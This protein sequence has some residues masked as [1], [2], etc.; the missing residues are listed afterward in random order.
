MT[1]FFGVAMG[2][3]PLWSLAVE[4]HFYILWPTVIHKLKSGSLILLLIA[5]CVLVPVARAIAFRYDH[6]VGIDWYTWFVA[7]GLAIG[8]LLAIVLRRPI[9]RTTVATLC[10]VFLTAIPIL[11][12]VAA[13]YGVLSRQRILGAAF[14]YT[15]ISIFFAGLLLLFLLLGTG[16]WKL[17]VNRPVLQFFGYI[18]YGLYL[19]HLMIFRIYDKVALA[20]RPQLEPSSWHFDLVVARFI[21]SGSAAILLSYASRKYYEEQFLR[22]KDRV[23]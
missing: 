21:I 20:F 3:G 11:A 7:D 14:Q 6:G 12:G 19:F 9:Q 17:W 5:I 13:R 1:S 18:S 15:L 22:L 16:P 10:T 23:A 4:E 8:S 2:Y